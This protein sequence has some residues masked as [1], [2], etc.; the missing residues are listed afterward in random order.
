MRTYDVLFE[1]VAIAAAQDLVQI[2]GAS[3]KVMFV[4]EMWAGVTDTSLA[5]GQGLKLRARF[6]PATVTNGSGGTTG[7]TPSK[8]DPGDAACS[9]STCATNN[10]T[11]ATTSGT[12]IKLYENGCHLYQGDR[13]RFPV[14]ERPPIGPS[15]AFV[16]ELLSTVTGTVH[17]SGGVKIGEVGG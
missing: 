1:D 9:S 17:M 5:T 13:Y 14:D 3:G 4:I 6:L 15:E 11:Q 2:T 16:W 8:V 12:A 7:I 10:T